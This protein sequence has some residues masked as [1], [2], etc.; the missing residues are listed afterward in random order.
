MLRVLRVLRL[1]IDGAARDGTEL[2]FRTHGHL[3][4]HDGQNDGGTNVAREF[5]AS[6]NLNERLSAQRG[7]ERKFL[8]MQIT[9]NEDGTTAERATRRERDVLQAR[10]GGHDVRCV[11]RATM[12][13]CGLARF[14]RT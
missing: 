13:A 6:G 9:P 5:N 8:V 2:T 4:R 12:R 14:L 1:R 3:F 10:D 7:S 11:T